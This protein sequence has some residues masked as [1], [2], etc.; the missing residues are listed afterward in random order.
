MISD[1]GPFNRST[2]DDTSGSSIA[3]L[4]PFSYSLVGEAGVG[5]G[6]AERKRASAGAGL[7]FNLHRLA[8]G[9]ELEEVTGARRG[10]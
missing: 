6:L 3:M 10:V 9:G 1:I 5:C 2:L 8:V 7:F 4:E